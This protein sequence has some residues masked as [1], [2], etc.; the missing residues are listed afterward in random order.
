MPDLEKVI[1]SDAKRAKSDPS[2]LASFRSLRLNQGVSDTVEAVVLDPQTW[3]RA[4]GQAPKDGGF[5][6]GIDLGTNA[7]MSA[8]AAYWPASGRLD[9]LALFPEIPSLDE[10]GLNDAVGALYVNMARRG[11]LMQAG[12]NVTDIA[13]LLTH[14][15]ERWGVPARVVCDR[16]REAELRQYLSAAGF[17]STALELRGQ[18]YKDGGQDVRDFRRAVLDSKVVPVPSLLIRAALAEARVVTDPAG[19]SKLAKRGG[20]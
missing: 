1:R 13:A 5:V 4:E 6:L 20:R 2:V 12:E 11:E 3:K 8:A 17:P 7:A 19:N 16:W 10:R 9:C 15:R 18:G 14:V